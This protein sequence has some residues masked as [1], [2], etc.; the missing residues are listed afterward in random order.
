MNSAANKLI[1]IEASAGGNAM[2]NIVARLPRAFQAPILLTPAG[3]LLEL[4]TAPRVRA[5]VE[6]S[7]ALRTEHATTLGR[8]SVAVLLKSTPSFFTCRTAAEPY[9]S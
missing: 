9:R 8:T 5:S 4:A 6:P 1:F 7:H 3:L 2:L